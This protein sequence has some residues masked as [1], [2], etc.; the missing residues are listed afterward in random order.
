MCD[1]DTMLKGLR[2]LILPT[3]DLAADRAWF[4]DALGIEPYFDEPFY[5]G[6]EVGGHELG[7]HPR[8]A[9]A[10]AEAYWGVDDLDAEMARMEARGATRVADPEDVGEGIRMVQLTTPT[11]QVV[12]LIENP[13]D[14]T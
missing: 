12:G 2:S 10:P 7:L 14:P 4:V 1:G 11:G 6:F 3:T 5:V 8:D 9:A 13:N